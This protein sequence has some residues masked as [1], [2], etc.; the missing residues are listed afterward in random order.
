MPVYFFFEEILETSGS[1][2]K[3]YDKSRAACNVENSEF[4]ILA[5]FLT[6]LSV[7]KRMEN[8]IF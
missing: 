7:W 4:K 2:A 5:L 8:R 1:H 6:S 3:K